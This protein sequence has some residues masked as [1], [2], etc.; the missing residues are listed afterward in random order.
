[1]KR[2]NVFTLLEK[3]TAGQEMKQ[4]N[5]VRKIPKASTLIRPN[6]SLRLSPPFFSDLSLTKKVALKNG[7]SLSLVKNTKKVAEAM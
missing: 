6:A 3:K 1:M 2:R 5:M 4:R 7:V